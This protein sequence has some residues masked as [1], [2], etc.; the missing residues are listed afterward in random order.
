MANQC[1]ICGAEINVFGTQKLADGSCIC[2]KNCRSKG[3][4]EFDYVHATL[5]Q[6]TA[7]IKQVENGTKLWEHYFI[8]KLKEKDKAKKLQRFSSNLYVAEDLGLMALTQVDYK[9]FIF[10]KSTRACVYRIADLIGY[11]MEE[12]EK[13][14]NNGTQK[15]TAAR[16]YFTKTEGMYEFTIP[17]P[18]TK[19]YQSLCKY[20][21]TLFGI[22]K[23]LGNAGNNAR[24][25]ID[26]IKSVASGIKAAVTDGANIDE[27]AANAAEALDNAIYGDRTGLIHR[28]DSALAAFHGS[29]AVI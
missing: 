13:K 29:E 28:A 5:P 10:G 1:S 18:N 12:I 16:L 8:P 17:L 27:K 23:T 26:A 4:R 11:D 7:H 2:R 22:Q 25:Q 19:A 20:F 15:E 6:V 9:F 3:F 24:K 14:T 21:D